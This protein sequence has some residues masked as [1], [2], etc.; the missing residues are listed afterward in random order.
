MAR[1]LQYGGMLVLL[2]VT[3]CQDMGPRTGFYASPLGPGDEVR[4]LRE[5]TVPAGDARVYLQRGAIRT[6][7]GTDQYAPFCYFLLRDP[8]PTE[9]QVPPGSF[10]VEA[11]RLEQ[12]DV[13]LQTPVRVAANLGVSAVG[14]LMAAWQFHIRLSAAGRPDMTLVCS[15]AFDTPARMA[16]IGL[17]QMRQALGDYAAIR[18]APRPVR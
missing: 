3:A 1:S 5:L 7:G 14:V 4:L 11:V 15:G 16:P 8:S 12:T 2:L 9:R 10:D 17:S 18:V 13:S 6:Y